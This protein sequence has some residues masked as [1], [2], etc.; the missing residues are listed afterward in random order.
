MAF[1]GTYNFAPSVG[2]LV[3]NAYGRIGIRRPALLAE[4][5]TDARIESNL[6]LTEFDNRG[7]NLWTVDLQSVPL[8]GGTANYTVP[9]ETITVLDAYITTNSG[10]ASAFDMIITSISRSDYAALPNKQDQGQPTLF[11]YDRLIAPSITLW[12][13]PDQSNTYTLNYYRYR[14][15]QDSVLTG[16]LQPE[17]PVRWLDAFTAALSARLARIY[18]PAMLAEAKTEAERTFQIAANQD[19]ENAPV[20]LTP[21]IDSYYHR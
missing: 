9:P 16:G 13:V 2:D 19:T 6:L 1:S 18:A 17:V 12:L 20:Y 7:V 5:M 10:S 3:Q 14:Q 8:I 4:H 21:A 11:W 15:I